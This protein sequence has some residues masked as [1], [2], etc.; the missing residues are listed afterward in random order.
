MKLPVIL[1]NHAGQRFDCH[2]CTNC[3]RDLVVHLTAADREKIDRQSWGGRLHALPYVPLG[4]EYVLNHRTNGGCVFLREDGLCRIHAEYGA[5]EKPLACQLFPFT[6]DREGPALRA[7]IRFDCPSVAGNRGSPLASHQRAIETLA[8][9]AVAE[10]SSLAFVEPAG[11]LLKTGRKLE[12]AELARL[13]DHIDSWLRNTTRS[14]EVRLLGLCSL[15]ETLWAVRPAGIRGER[16]GELVSLLMQDLPEAAKEAMISPVVPPTGRQKRLLR[17][18]VFAHAEHISLGQAQASWWSSMRY[19]FSQLG[20]ARRLARASGALPP[21]WPGMPP[22]TLAALEGVTGEA[23]GGGVEE[24]VTRYLRVRV[25]SHGVFGSA[26][27]G[28]P[29][30]E[31]LAALVLSVVVTAWL[32]RYH[33]AAAGRSAITPDDAVGAI[34]LVDRAAGRARELGSASARLRVRYLRADQGLTRLLRAYSLVV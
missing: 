32:A 29:V 3:C 20:K 10:I 2:S 6:L 34:G 22:V 31:G 28:W 19:R 21:L 15:I 7:S 27:Y 1:P 13:V 16:F 4:R 18:A 25:L 33:A 9:R 24:L 8:N 12:E 14:L 23:G 11:V 30:L 26:Y 5:E 17:Q